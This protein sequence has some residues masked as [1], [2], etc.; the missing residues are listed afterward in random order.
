MSAAIDLPV[1]LSR[2][3][4]VGAAFPALVAGEE[5]VLWR[6]SGGRL[7]A[8]PDRCP[9]RAPPTRRSP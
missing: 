2:D 6:D 7:R 8:W 1:A 9:H 3:I 4:A 5:I